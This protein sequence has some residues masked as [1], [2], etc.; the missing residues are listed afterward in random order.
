MIRRS[1][2]QLAYPRME[3]PRVRELSPRGP[4]DRV[5]YATWSLI[6]WATG[7]SGCSWRAGRKKNTLVRALEPLGGRS[8]A[9]S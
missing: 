9:D 5:R 7:R 6:R 1:A 8:G 4:V 3:N 2:T